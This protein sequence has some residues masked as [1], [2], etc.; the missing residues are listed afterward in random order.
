[1]RCFL[2]I[3]SLS[4]D[5]HER[6]IAGD[7]FF[8]VVV[9]ELNISISV[10]RDAFGDQ[11]HRR[12]KRAMRIEFPGCAASGDRWLHD[13]IEWCFRNLIALIVMIIMHEDASIV[14]I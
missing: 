8:F 5:L 13:Q 2:Q 7:L 4:F 14:E 3:R 11:F 10:L 12:Q 1:M 9:T 6:Q